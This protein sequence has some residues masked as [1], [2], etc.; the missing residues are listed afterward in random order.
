M[1]GSLFNVLG[2]NGRRPLRRNF[3]GLAL[4][5]ALTGGA[6]AMLVPILRSLL[7]QDYPNVWLWMGLLSSLLIVYSAV[8]FLTQIAAYTAAV[9][10]ARDLFTRIE[11]HI[12]RLPLGWFLQKNIGAFSNLLSQG[13]IDIMG[14]PAHLLRPLTQA[15]FTPLAVCLM[16]FLFDWRLAIAC[17][18]SIPVVLLTFQWSGSRIKKTDARTHIAVGAAADKI[19]EFAQAQQVLR[20]Y[21]GEKA[22][23][24]TLDEALVEQYDAGRALTFTGAGGIAVVMTVVQIVFI[25]IL[26]LSVNLALGGA[27]DAAEFIALSVLVVRYAEPLALAADL[28]GALRISGAKLERMQALLAVKPFDEPAT[29]VTPKDHKIAF[30]SVAFSYDDRPVLKDMSF[31]AQDGA[32]TAIVG[33]SGAGKT[34]ILRLIARFW[35]ACDGAVTIG[36]VDIR[37]I[38]AADLMQ[39]ISIV[40]QD[41][42]LFDGS[43]REN[44]LIGRP[45]ASEEDIANAMRL[46]QIDEIIARLPDGL[47]TR[48]GDGGAALSGGEAQRVS[49]ARALIKDAPII[50]LDEASSALDPVSQHRL[51]K[52][53]RALS[54]NKTL[55]IVAHQ[56]AT[57]RAADQ[58]LFVDDGRIV[59]VGAHDE[60]IA[61]DGRYAS[62]WREREKS[63]C[64]RLA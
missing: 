59:E 23:N 3:Y 36:D 17:L 7:H 14:V 42:Y 51:Q 35:D 57:I 16:M 18:F 4:E 25:V 9:N 32:M 49:I 15:L 45:D 61:R 12:A 46:A 58:I 29:S 43:I 27:I 55:V 6:F 54:K 38:D 11:K 33:P 48:T 41:V 20:A 10:L 28:D 26:I 64:W 1:I 50:L 30:N 40:F 22:A 19:V 60:L 13:V 52:A 62:F 47:D 56:L 2:E 34:T 63:K 21:S 24:R 8:R 39:L 5:S 37:E 44:I 53:L 31:T